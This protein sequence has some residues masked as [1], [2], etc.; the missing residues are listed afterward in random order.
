MLDK[1]KAKRVEVRKS[2]SGSTYK[3]YYFNCTDCEKEISSQLSQLRAH[4]GKCIRCVQLGQPYMFIYNE[5]K[6]HRNR[7]VEFNLTYQ[8]LLAIIEKP[9]CSYCEC[10][11]V[12]YKHSKEW[13][14]ANTR[15]HQLD[16][17]DNSQGYTMDNVV[18]CC[19]TCN[20]LKSNVFTYE[21]FMLLAPILKQIR[22]NKEKNV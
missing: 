17:K 21:E 13:S 3:T 16:R 7:S 1:A 8:D 19:W 12:Y 15:A 4:S 9:V 2:N 5:L 18:P 20:R 11:L 6:N 10:D 22:L 14:I